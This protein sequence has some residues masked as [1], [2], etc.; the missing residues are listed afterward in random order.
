MDSM[1]FAWARFWNACGIVD[2]RRGEEF[3]IWV[4]AFRLAA[5]VFDCVDLLGFESIEGRDFLN[6]EGIT[7]KGG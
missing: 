5:F 4:F 1:C 2:C 3:W 6:L 7:M